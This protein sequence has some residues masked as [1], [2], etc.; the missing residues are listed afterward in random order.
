MVTI[1][2]SFGSTPLSYVMICWNTALTALNMSSETV[3][4]RSLNFFFYLYLDCEAV[5]TAATPGL[6]LNLLS[7]YLL[8]VVPQGRGCRPGCWGCC[9][10]LLRSSAAEDTP[11]DMWLEENALPIVVLG[12]FCDFCFTSLP[13]RPCSLD[14][15]RDEVPLR[16]PNCSCSMSVSMYCP[17]RAFLVHVISHHIQ[18]G[19]CMQLAQTRPNF[20]HL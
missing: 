20:W 8:L 4:I 7:W 10:V 19:G 11:G 13:W 1:M 18:Q 2:S 12:A 17:F 5:G 9:C 15:W 14:S 16:P 3:C 6:S